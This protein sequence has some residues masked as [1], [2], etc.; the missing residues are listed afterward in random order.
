MTGPLAYWHVDDIKGSSLAQPT[1]YEAY[2][3]PS[4]SSYPIIAQKR[5]VKYH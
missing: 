5:L 4:S 1:P 3:Y 2:A